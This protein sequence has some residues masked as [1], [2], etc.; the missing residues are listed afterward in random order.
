MWPIELVFAQRKY[1]L[2]V[3]VHMVEIKFI[4]TSVHVVDQLYMWLKIFSENS[5]ANI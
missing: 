2:I 4:R 1:F 5:V 3:F